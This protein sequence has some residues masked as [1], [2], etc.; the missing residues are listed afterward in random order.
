M[1]MEHYEE[2]SR[3]G[4][5]AD[6]LAFI[7]L[8]LVLCKAG[9]TRKATCMVKELDKENLIVNVRKSP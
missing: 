8:I 4:I 7:A 1:G 2:M 3:N 5:K 9:K 6:S